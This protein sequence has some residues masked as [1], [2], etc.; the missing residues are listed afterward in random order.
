MRHFSGRVGAILIGALC[1][2]APLTAAAA[3]CSDCT[4]AAAI[5]RASQDDNRSRSGLRAAGGFWLFSA[6]FDD[7]LTTIP[8]ALAEEVDE[9]V[10]LF[11]HQR[12]TDDPGNPIGEYVGAQ[13]VYESAALEGLRHQFG[14]AVGF[15]ELATPFAR[16]LNRSGVDVAEREAIYELKFRIEV[17]EGFALQSDLQFIRNP[18]MDAGVD[19]SWTV[20]LRFEI[21]AR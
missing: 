10:D 4:V 12:A 8:R 19:S 6:Q 13:V 17:S 15:A 14:V 16:A 11:L 3:E 7:L 20:G 1:A 18:G 9:D 5:A 2:T 21:G